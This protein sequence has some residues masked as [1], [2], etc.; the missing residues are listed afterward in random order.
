MVYPFFLLTLNFGFCAN[1]YNQSFLSEKQLQATFLEFN[2]SKKQYSFL[3]LRNQTINWTYLS[4]NPKNLNSSLGTIV[5]S[6]G[7]TES[8]LNWSELSV[9]FKNAGYAVAIIDHISQGQSERIVHDKDIGHID[10]FESYSDDF[11]L[12]LSSVKNKTKGPYY[13]IG[14][15]MGAPIALISDTSMFKKIEIGRASCRERVYLAV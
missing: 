9:A 7:R 15:S 2:S 11:N 4:T 10:H 5:I 6:P 14:N 3:N 1:A 12:F 8:S 13:L